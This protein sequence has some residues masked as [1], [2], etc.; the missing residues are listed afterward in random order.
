M[1]DAT[2]NAGVGSSKIIFCDFLCYNADFPKDADVDG[3]RTCRTFAAVWC[4]ELEAY[5][6]KNA[7]CAVV[8]GKRRPKDVW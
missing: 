8:F 3:S 2:P 4:R 7:P 5:V 1:G 6:T